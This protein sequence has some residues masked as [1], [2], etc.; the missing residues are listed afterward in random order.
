M[1]YPDEVKK[2]T[3]TGSEIISVAELKTYAGINGTGHDTLLG[4][5]ILAVRELHEEWVRLSYVSR[6]IT[7]QWSRMDGLYIRLPFGPV[8]SIDSVKRVYDD[9]TL[10]DALVE[11]TDYYVKGMDFPELKFYARWTSAGKVITGL[12]VVYD[13]GYGSGS[14]EADAPGQLKQMMLKHLATDYKNRDDLEQY[15]PVMY[16]WIK[17]GLAPYRKEIAWL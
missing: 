7:A 13:C 14:G 8:Y 2:S 10:S 3:A 15:I 12:R 11:G 6:S 4:E 17:T 5:M 9:G 16:E 1:R